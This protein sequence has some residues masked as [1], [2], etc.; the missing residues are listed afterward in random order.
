MTTYIVLG[1]G[2]GHHIK[3]LAAAARKE[4]L[5]IVVEKD[6]GI[7]RAAMESVDMRELFASRRVVPIVGKDVTGVF[8][9][10]G[11]HVVKDIPRRRLPRAPPVGA[12]F[13]RVLH[14]RPQGLRRL[15]HLRDAKRHHDRLDRR[16][17]EEKLPDEPPVPRG[18]PRHRPLQGR[19]RRASRR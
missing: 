19:V 17:V 10:L 3:A 16:A 11:P 13:S 9:A 14:H 2:L 5:I 4:S 8:K 1:F 7:F 15:R 6:L 18:E 12:G